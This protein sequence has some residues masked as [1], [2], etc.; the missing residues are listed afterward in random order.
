MII[1]S[2]LKHSEIMYAS[3]SSKGEKSRGLNGERAAVF[4]MDMFTRFTDLVPV[5]DKTAEEALRAIRY[6]LGE[7]K[8]GRLYSDNSKELEVA[9]KELCVMHQAATPHRPQ[10][11]AFAERGIRTMLE[12]TRASLLQA[13]LL[14]R[15]WLIA[16]RH[17][18][19]ATA[20]VGGSDGET[21]PWMKVCLL[22]TS[23]SPRDKRQSRMPS[24]A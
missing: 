9:A 14:P 2:T 18:A 21:S 17:H 23:P 13:G 20:I 24:S 15:F 11:N 12:G 6:F 5:A 4:I 7:H 19:F 3:A 10:T 1:V 16:G 22:Y 8:D